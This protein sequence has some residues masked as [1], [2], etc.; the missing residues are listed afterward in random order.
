MKGQGRY[1]YEI[2]N[3]D[4]SS[5]VCRKDEQMINGKGCC[6]KNIILIGVDSSVNKTGY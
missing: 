1:C 3:T 2:H 6:D 4:G 5:D